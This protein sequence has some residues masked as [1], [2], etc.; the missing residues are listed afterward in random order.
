MST[1]LGVTD[2]GMRPTA[3]G[4][5]ACLV[6]IGIRAGPSP[7][8]RAISGRPTPAGRRIPCDRT[9]LGVVCRGAPAS[10]AVRRP[11]QSPSAEQFGGLG[12]MPADLVERWEA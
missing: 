4:P 8:E 3:S 11:T 5:N 10:G 7:D 6:G 9:R 2:L 1:E 12:M